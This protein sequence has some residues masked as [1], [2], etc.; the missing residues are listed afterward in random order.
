MA[1]VFISYARADKARVAPLVAAIEARGWS[2]WWDPEISPGREFDDAIDTE[3][4]AAKA[5]LV[6]WTPTSVASRWVRGEAR[7]AAERNIL[8]PVRFGQAR[9]PIDVRAIHTIDLDDWNENPASAPAQACLQALGAMIARSSQVSAKDAGSKAA[10]AAKPTPRFSICVLPVT[11]M[12]GE[13]DQEYFSD[14]ITED[15]ITDLSKVST[16]R[17]IS[18]NSAF[19]YKGKNV[20]LPKVASEL[21]VTHVLE[22]SVRKAGG[23]VRISA[24]LIDGESNGHLWAERYDRDDDDI[25]AIQDE[26]SQAIAK[27]LKLHLLPEEK[28]AIRK[29]GT[30]NAK[31]HD[32]YLM[33]RQTYVTSQSADPNAA[34]AV[35][36]ICK[37]AT[38][39]D[40]DYA[41]AWALMATGFRQLNWMQ[42]GE[43]DDGTAAIDRALELNPDLGE[44][45]AVKAQIL[46]QGNDL[47]SAAREAAIALSLDPESYEVN[48]AAGQLY[49]QLQKFPDAVRYYEKAVALMEADINSAAMLVSCYTAVGDA[50]GTRRAA[51]MTLKRAEAILAH[52]QNN[53]G[54]TAYSVDALAALGDAERAKVRMERA[55]LIDPDNFNMRYNFAC[56]LAVR[57]G[58]KA[59]ALE[60]LEPLFESISDSFLAY[61]KADPD[62]DSLHDD[63]RYKAMVAAAE[64][65]LGTEAGRAR[66]TAT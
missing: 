61:A 3:L 19:R 52:D 14:G 64:A 39:I 18:R 40:P 24:Q 25:F 27:A 17:V 47:E 45:H 59:A 62:L 5:V 10:V 9:L 66:V 13:V 42:S 7:D 49:Y 6:V 30:D 28:K 2:V 21:N 51:E 15:I 8:V 26:I 65:R 57:L 54:V 35:V 60:M 53:V 20:D 29:R 41:E 23:R 38:E 44:T 34:R 50:A 63:P 12:S 37:R 22:G 1:D 43:T 33:A 58:E 46:Q 32:L 11:N 36:R 56:V 31:A 4:Q 48:R 16:L 55:L